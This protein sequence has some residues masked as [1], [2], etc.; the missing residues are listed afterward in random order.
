MLPDLPI[1]AVITLFF[2]FASA[3]NLI[4]LIRHIRSGQKWT[5]T[6]L[7]LLLASERVAAYTVRIVWIFRPTSIE[8]AISARVLLDSG[9][10]VLYTCSLV[11][12]AAIVRAGSGRHTW[13]AILLPVLF[14]MAVVAPIVAVVSVVVQ[15]YT[16]DT[17]TLANCLYAQRA[18]ALFFA[19]LA[20]SPLPLLVAAYFGHR[21]HLFRFMRGRWVDGALV[22]TSA[23]VSMIVAG[24]RPVF[25]GRQRTM[26]HGTIQ[27]QRS[28]CF[29]WCQRWRHL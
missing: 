29:N 18:M 7:L 20:T 9:V 26:K 25:C 12:V 1:T 8:M 24:L 28:T 13:L 3:L 22:V 17:K 23:I 4:L 19:A 27:E 15:A 5:L 10:I 14:A 6:A 21:R 2:V 16:V 11:Y